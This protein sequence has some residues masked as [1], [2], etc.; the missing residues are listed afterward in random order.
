MRILSRRYF[1]SSIFL[2]GATLAPASSE[3]LSFSKAAVFCHDA[4]R[5]LG[6]VRKQS[7]QII[8]AKIVSQGSEAVKIQ[9]GRQLGSGVKGAVYS[10]DDAA[11]Q[12]ALHCQG[13]CVLKIPH[14]LWPL[15][16]GVARRQLASHFYAEWE[17]YKMVRQVNGGK[18]KVPV[19]PITDLVETAAGPG[20]VKPLA[21]GRPL[22]QMLRSGYQLTSS[23]EASLA[24]LRQRVAQLEKQLAT[25]DPKILKAYPNVARRWPGHISIDAHNDNLFW[26]D[27]PGLL[28]Q[29]G[30]K[31]PSF[32]FYELT[33]K[34]A[35][36]V[37]P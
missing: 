5:E 23:Q 16:P 11:S 9:M 21:P 4:F 7:D 3:A 8:E 19:L 20:L 33:F 30:L 10:I 15:N 2:V 35:H 32:V 29:C 37:V 24:D 31:E 17:F 14:E 1:V 25:V 22:G 6:L 28:A 36:N 13:P 12:A 26:L 27:D 34:S 18:F